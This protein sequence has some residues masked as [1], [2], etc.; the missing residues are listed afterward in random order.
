MGV[1]RGDQPPHISSMDSKLLFPLATAFL[2][3]CLVETGSS[4]K[5][6]QCNSYDSYHCADP[7]YYEDSP[8]TPKTLEF[9]QDCPA[10]T[11]DKT[12]FCRKIYQNA[13]ACPPPCCPPLAWR[14]S[15]TNTAAA[16][17]PGPV[18]TVMTVLRTT[19]TPS[20]GQNHKHTCC[21]RT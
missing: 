8:D 18:S 5:C 14:T 3:L 6:H 17:L 13:L 16:D 11:A 20:C 2:V 1:R 9:L 21:A 4:I 19:S 10:D 15:F 7:F 12:Y